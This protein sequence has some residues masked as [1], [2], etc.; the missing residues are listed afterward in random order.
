[1][2]LYCDRL[3]SSTWQISLCQSQ[4]FLQKCWASSIQENIWDFPGVLWGSK[5]HPSPPCSVQKW[6]LVLFSPTSNRG[7]IPDRQCRHRTLQVRGLFPH[8]LQITTR[9]IQHSRAKF[10]L[11]WTL[12]PARKTLNDF[13]Y[14]WLCWWRIYKCIYR[15]MHRA[16]LHISHQ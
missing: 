13:P 7:N 8:Y 1:M 14:F 5:G 16:N 15:S 11:L 4:L 12:N 10:P 2:S 6:P 9:W 3:N